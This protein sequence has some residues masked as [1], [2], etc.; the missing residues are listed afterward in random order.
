MKYIE[1]EL[2]NVIP[3]A[4]ELI[5]EMTLDCDFKD[6]TYEMLNDKEFQ[7][8]LREHYPLVDWPKPFEEYK[9]APTRNQNS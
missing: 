1:S 4:D 2:D 3:E 6:V 5:K 7:E 8:A 9:A